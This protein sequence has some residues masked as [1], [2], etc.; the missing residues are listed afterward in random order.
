MCW[1]FGILVGWIDI[2]WAL[3]AIKMIKYDPN[4]SKKCEI[5]IDGMFN[6]DFKS[7]L[8]TKL[9]NWVTRTF[10]YYAC[11]MVQSKCEQIYQSKK[12]L[13]RLNS[14][15]VYKRIKR[16]LVQWNDA[17]NKKNENKTQDN[18]NETK[19]NDTKEK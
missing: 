8:P 3:G 17:Q 5:E 18:K 4:D 12:H 14:K 6:V 1:C 19:S 7:F 15:K 2:T 9:L 10:A 11:Q 16:Q 13:Q